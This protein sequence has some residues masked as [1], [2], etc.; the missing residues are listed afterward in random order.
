MFLEL[1]Y[2]LNPL[3]GKNVMR[4][5]A[6]VRQGFSGN[7]QCQLAGMMPLPVW[8]LVGCLYQVYLPRKGL[9][10]RDISITMLVF[11]KLVH[12]SNMP[13]SLTVAIRAL[14]FAP[15]DDSNDA[16]NPDSAFPYRID[17]S[18]TIQATPC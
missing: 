14:F 7:E 3:V 1:P 16:L 10:E 11:I 4:I 8:Q 2:H 13:S 5:T 18:F 17:A 9:Q 12:T 15:C 6:D